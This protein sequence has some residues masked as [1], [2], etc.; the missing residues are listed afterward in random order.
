MNELKQFKEKKLDEFEKKFCNNHQ[1]PIRF[2]RSVFYDEQ[3]GAEQIEQFISDL[4]D[5][6][7]K[8]IPPEHIKVEEFDNDSELM[9]IGHNS[10][11]KDLITNLNS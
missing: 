7:E 4:I 6:V 11:R 2:L 5:E 8:A 10:C 1:K 9:S 3:D